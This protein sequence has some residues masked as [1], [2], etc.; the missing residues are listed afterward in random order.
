MLQG[1]LLYHV[2]NP[3]AS[4]GEIFH[5]MEGLK[6]KKDILEDYTVSDTSL[7]QVFLSFA[8]EKDSTVTVTS[9]REAGI[10]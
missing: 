8:K 2:T 10:V 7:E 6:G 9:V 1:M 5:F 4:L 3:D